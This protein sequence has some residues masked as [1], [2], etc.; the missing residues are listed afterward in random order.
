MAPYSYTQTSSP[1]SPHGGE[2]GECSQAYGHYAGSWHPA[3]TRRPA[4]LIAL[5]EEKM[6]SV[7]KHMATMLAHGTLQLHADQLS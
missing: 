6:V 3:A 5:M 4:L 1:D 2:D 7:A